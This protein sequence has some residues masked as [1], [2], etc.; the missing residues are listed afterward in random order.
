VLT[1]SRSLL[2]VSSVCIVGAVGWFMVGGTAVQP[3][4]PVA[5]FSIKKTAQQSMSR[6]VLVTNALGESSSV[7]SETPSQQAVVAQTPRSFSG[8]AFAPSIEDTEID[9][10]LTADAAGNLIVDLDV[11]DLFDYFMNTV[12]DVEPEVAMAE[13]E[14]LARGHLPASAAD[15]AMSLLVDYLHYKEAAVAYGQRSMLPAEQQTPE[16]QLAMLEQSFNDLKEIRRATMSREAVEAFFGLEEAYGEY[17]LSTIRIQSD[18]DLSPQEQQ[19]QMEQAR[20]Q[21]PEMIQKSEIAL[22]QDIEVTRDVNTL[23]QSSLTDNE[24]EDQLVGL[25]LEQAAIADALAYREQQRNFN[26]V[27]QRYAIE[28]E[29]LQQSGLS[30][31]DVQSETE[32]LR[33]KYFH[34]EQGLTQARVRDL[35]S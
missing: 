22:Q 32:R 20:A 34:N 3:S 33:N 24:L 6:P 29:Q 18:A 5:D 13:L 2:V 19:L 8:K 14:K 15:Q 21:L 23:M 26:T 4:S 31:K 27:Y 11:R 16:Y 12:A 10:R 17:T 9:G 25:G 35:S 28:R 7:A 1:K 30:S